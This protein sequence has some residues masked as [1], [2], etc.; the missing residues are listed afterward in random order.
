[1]VLCSVAD[2][3]AYADPASVSDA[4]VTAIIQAVSTEVLTKAEAT[5]ESNAFLI[6]AGI[7]GS[8]AAVLKKA[9]SNGE[10][11]SSVKTPEYEQQN[12]GINDEINTHEKEMNDYIQRYQAS[13]RYAD[14][15]ILYSR[16]GIGTVNAD[17]Q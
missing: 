13:V 9:R 16:V 4:D 6:Q 8:V 2:V 3:H 7:H 14:Y 15:S 1:M 12:N 5:D 17:L 11:A 10:L